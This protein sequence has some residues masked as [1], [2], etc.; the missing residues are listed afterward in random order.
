MIGESCS[1][2]QNI[3]I[4][5]NVRVGNG[6]KIQNNVSLYEGAEFEDCVICGPSCVFTNYLTPRLKHSKGYANYVKMGTC[7]GANAVVTSDVTDYA[8]M[9]GVPAKSRDWVCKYEERLHG[10]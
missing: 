5:N 3:N 8:L 4:S 6:C 2:G 9:L 7:I 1:H 10:E